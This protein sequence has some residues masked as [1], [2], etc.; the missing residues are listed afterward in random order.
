M[1]TGIVIWSLMAVLGIVAS[2]FN[3]GHLFFTALPSAALA[4]ASVAE[5]RQHKKRECTY[6]IN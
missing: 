1:K 5:Y 3:F 6:K 4:A 2:F